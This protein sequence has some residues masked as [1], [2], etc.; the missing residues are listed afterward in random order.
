MRGLHNGCNLIRWPVWIAPKLIKAFIDGNEEGLEAGEKAVIF[1]PWRLSLISFGA[2]D[3]D[4]CLVKQ[5]AEVAVRSVLLRLKPIQA[6][7]IKFRFGIGV[8]H[9]HTLEEIGQK[10]G[11]TRERIRQIEAE[12][13]KKLDKAGR[14]L[15]PYHEASEWRISK[16]VC[17]AS[18]EEPSAFLLRERVA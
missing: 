4:D 14:S 2:V 13:L 16:R 3:L 15:L 9:E 1:V 8:D 10:F 12:G 5:E 6:S 7:V 11:L 17:S 18:H